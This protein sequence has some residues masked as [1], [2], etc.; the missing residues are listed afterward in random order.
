MFVKLVRST[1]RDDH[2][3]GEAID[4]AGELCVADRP[5]FRIVNLE[6]R[7]APMLVDF[8]EGRTGFIKRHCGDFGDAGTIT[9]LCRT[10]CTFEAEDQYLNAFVGRV[11]QPGLIIRLAANWPPDADGLGHELIER[12]LR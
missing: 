1:G 11:E 10:F 2:N 4:D 7:A 5:A 6:L 3:S 8:D 9:V 12:E